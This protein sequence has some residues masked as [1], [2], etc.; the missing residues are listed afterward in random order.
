M[1]FIK[2]IIIR[3]IAIGF[4]IQSLGA[5]C[6]DCMFTPVTASCQHVSPDLGQEHSH[7][8]DAP[9]PCTSSLCSLCGCAIPC[10]SC[11]SS[12]PIQPTPPPPFVNSLYKDA[13][14]N[15]LFRP[16]QV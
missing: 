2:Q 14:T 5:L 16:P 11:A 3:L 7:S 13:P 15:S 12:H 1:R 9:E 6:D 8:P 10:S 4:L